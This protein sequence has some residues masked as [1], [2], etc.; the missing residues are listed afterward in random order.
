MSGAN[1]LLVA[2]V[3]YSLLWRSHIVTFGHDQRIKHA[4]NNDCGEATKYIVRTLILLI[5]P[6]TKFVITT[7]GRGGDQ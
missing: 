3:L 6:R 2:L 4:T 1:E 5:K 7:E